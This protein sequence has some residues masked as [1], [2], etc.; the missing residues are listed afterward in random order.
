MT[1]SQLCIEL[2]GHTQPLSGYI[3]KPFKTKDLEKWYNGEVPE[4][5]EH[6]SRHSCYPYYAMF[7]RP[8][9]AERVKSCRTG[10]RMT[11]GQ[12]KRINREC[13][14]ARSHKR[15][16]WYCPECV[17]EDFARKGETCWRRLPQMPG[18]TYCPV[19]EVRFRESNIRFSDIDYQLIPATYALL[20]LP[21][22]EM[23]NTKVYTDRYLLLS[24]DIAWLLENGFMV[25]DNEGF[26]RGFIESTGKPVSEHLFYR[27]ANA[28]SRG[29]R[30]EDYL[31]AR[32]MSDSGKEWI[33]EQTS[34]QIGT[35]LSIEETYG[36]FEAFYGA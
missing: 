20:H 1:S 3:F 32:I 23:A 11:A 8:V 21:E 36:C 28:R 22:G 13:G 33:T 16:L 6:G 5:I 25:A 14:F 7:L 4:G 34:R 35:I 27:T 18:A 31:A 26:R 10:S 15:N 17:K 2:F 29:S 30:F 12:A 19:H 9:H 24:R